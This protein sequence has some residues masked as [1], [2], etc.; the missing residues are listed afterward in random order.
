MFHE[1]EDLEEEE[2]E[3][4]IAADPLIHISEKKK[5]KKNRNIIRKYVAGI[6]NNEIIFPETSFSEPYLVKKF[7]FKNLLNILIILF[8]IIL[9]T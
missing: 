5:K 8:L 1:V 9:K 2:E 4:P 7:K 3:P 6:Q